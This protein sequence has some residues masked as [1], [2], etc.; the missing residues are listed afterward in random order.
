MG[1]EKKQIPSKDLWIIIMC[2]W[3]SISYEKRGLLDEDYEKE[4]IWYLRMLR[5]FTTGKGRRTFK[6]ETLT[7][8]SYKIMRPSNTRLIKRYYYYSST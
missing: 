7:T 2:H 3:M 5:D 8:N 6:L 1:G 4:E